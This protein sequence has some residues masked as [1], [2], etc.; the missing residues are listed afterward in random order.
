MQGVANTLRSYCQEGTRAVRAKGPF[1]KTPVYAV[2]RSEYLHPE[3]PPAGSRLPRWLRKIGLD[4]PDTRRNYHLWPLRWVYGSRPRQELCELARNSQSILHVGC[5]SGWLTWEMAL[6]NPEAQIVAVEPRAS[7]LEWARSNFEE[8]RPTARVEFLKQKLDDLQ[9][10]EQKFDL[11]VLSF[12]VR[13]ANDPKGMLE[14][15]LPRLN[16]GARVFYYEGTEP[17]PLNLERI[18]KWMYRR[19]RVGGLMTDLWN[20]RRRL[21]SLYLEDAVRVGTRAANFN[22]ADFYDSLH[23]HFE[24]DQHSRRR[25]FVDMLLSDLSK[26]SLWV[27]LPVYLAC[28]RLL[29]STAYLEGCCRVAVGHLKPTATGL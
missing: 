16:P 27:I 8:R 2:K 14:R 13:R 22:E 28:D 9:L 1:M 7:L 24:I 10:P 18:S 29:V 26:R 20:Q 4:Q 11:V 19:S 6:A 21:Q 17:T 23:T 5:E 12:S 3:A 25:A 15:I